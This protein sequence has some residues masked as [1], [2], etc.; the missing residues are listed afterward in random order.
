[1]LFNRSLMDK[2]LSG[3]K[4]ETRRIWK[5]CMVKENRIYAARTDY[6]KDSVFAYIYIKYVRRERLC[7]MD[8]HSAMLEGFS[9]LDEFKY[10]WIR[11]Y[12]SWNPMQEVYV[13][14]FTTVIPVYNKIISRELNRNKSKSYENKFNY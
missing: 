9:S 13:I 12:G 3:R 14:G 11:C 6:S 10:V 7:D 8:D 5:R 4:V 1:M 2:I